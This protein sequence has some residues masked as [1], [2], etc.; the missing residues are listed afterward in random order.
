MRKM[1]LIPALLSTFPALAQTY[2]G[3][4]G[5]VPDNGVATD[6]T[7]NVSGLSPSTL[8]ATHGLLN[9]CLDITHT[10]NADLDIKIIAPDGNTVTLA[11]GVGGGDDNFTGTCFDMSAPDEIAT[12]SA[13]FTGTWNPMGLL[14]NVNNGQNGNGTWV[15]RITDTWAQDQG[16]LNAWSITFGNSPAIPFVFTS[17]N[18]P[19]IILNTANVSI[20]DEPKIP[21]TMK[22]IY[23]GAGN[24][25]HPSDPATDYDGNIGI[26]MR[27]A[28]SQ[29]LPQKPYNI[30]LRDAAG[31]E[32]DTSLLGMPAE[33]DW[34]L[35]ANYNDKSF[36]RNALA[37]KLFGE[38]NHYSTRF[39]FC[40]VM[41][42]N[43]Y[44]G[45]Y[46][47]MESI[48]RDNNRVD[49]AKLDT[50]ENTGLDVTGGYIIKN[51]YWDGSN[52]W[53]LNYHPIDHPTM[54]VH[55]VYHYPKADNITTAQ[56]NYIAGFVDN[57]ESA[58]YA[59]N[60]SDTVIGYRAW[61]HVYSFIDYLLVNELARN[62]DG[63]KKSSYFH[64]GKDK[65]TGISKLKAGPVW[66]FDWAWKDIWG[67]SIFEATDGSG[68]AH[69]INDCGPDVNS[70]GWYVRMMQDTNFTNLTRCRWEQL[71]T[72]I[73]DTNHLF[74]YIDSCASEFQAAQQRHYDY[75]GHMGV[76]SG[77]PEVN[78][79]AQSYA[80]EIA[81]FNDWIRR[82]IE[83]LDQNIPGNTG[84]CEWLG[85]PENETFETR[86]FP[87]PAETE[88]FIE[89]DRIIR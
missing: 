3:T 41:L 33:H 53:L 7:L 71:R 18:L 73:L 89:S 20:P 57:F 17:T 15:L 80:E 38:M 67:C 85:T 64:K 63:F 58:L 51:D 61:A 60:F 62:N 32:L 82:R 75:W 86:I 4:G 35:I 13:P 42:N 5:T 83:W 54:D 59:S 81:F 12:A 37:Y 8:N 79:P 44:Q 36:L 27:G 40:E 66:D 52:S 47:F 2:T 55:L 16:T 46:L 21:G 31:L 65:S 25:N 74:H 28:Y 88:L 76:S 70:P 43:E 68:W 23:N 19:L 49:I 69:H 45:V 84:A 1:A 14:G 29:S 26:E 48:K 34:Q 24:M 87:N 50:N 10:Y 77:A 39:R 6:F 11:S 56:K 78:A 30:E 22:I 9:V 72:S